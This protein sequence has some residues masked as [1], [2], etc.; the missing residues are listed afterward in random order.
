[1]SGKI[2]TLKN[3]MS[4]QNY[5]YL[6]DIREKKTGG[7]CGMIAIIKNGFGYLYSNLE[8]AFHILLIIL[9]KVWI[10]LFSL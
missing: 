4:W 9:R 8:F 1:M 7:A 10:Q 2:T 3:L 6:I 5:S